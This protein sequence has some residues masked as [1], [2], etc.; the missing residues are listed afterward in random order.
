MPEISQTS[1]IED[2]AQIA[3][4]V[5]I[6][7]Y[8]YIGTGVKIGAGCIIE[9]NVAIVGQTTL[10]KSCHVFPMAVIGT[11]FDGDDAR[12][13][14]TIGNANSIREHVTVYAGTSRKPTRL[15]Q[16]NLVMIASQIG[17]GAKIGDHN[18]FANSTHIADGATIEDYVRTSA[19]STIDRGV[20]VGAYTFTAGYVHVDHD[21]PPYA[22]VQGSP[23]RVRGV[24]S[25]NL[26][27]CGFDDDDIRRLKSVF[28]DLF[29]GSGQLNGE[30][31]QTLR[32]ER[33][34][35]AVIEALLEFVDNHKLAVKDR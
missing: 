5:T 6:G 1:I 19:F 22:M 15:G 13:K 4:D 24:N 11:T 25:H 29:N 35:P 32:S 9:N 10:G 27:Q 26:K 23:F 21:A 31:L 34:K 20:T 12:G 16:N 2:G 3:K 14:C 18:I 28:R 8:C 17:P 30:V 33:Q 7:P